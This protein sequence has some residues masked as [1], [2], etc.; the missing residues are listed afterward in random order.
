MNALDI[1]GR[2]LET[3]DRQKVDPVDP[4]R[5]VESTAIP[6]EKQHGRPGRPGRPEKTAARE[7]SEAKTPPFKRWRVSVHH[8]DGE[9]SFDMLTPASHS[10]ADATDAA[11]FHFAE[12]L[13]AVS[14]VS[15]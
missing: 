1:I 10:E 13:I 5:S 11:W 15:A 4:G 8:G 14:E 2:A 9:R 3:V 6:F 7:Q 12:R